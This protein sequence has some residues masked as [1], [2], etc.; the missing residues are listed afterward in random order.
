MLNPANSP[1]VMPLLENVY[2]FSCM[3]QGIL[4]L[5]MNSIVAAGYVPNRACDSI[6][7]RALRMI[8]ENKPGATLISEGHDYAKDD[9][10][11]MWK[12]AWNR[13]VSCLYKFIPKRAGDKSVEHILNVCAGNTKTIVQNSFSHVFQR[14]LEDCEPTEEETRV[15][16]DEAKSCGF[17]VYASKEERSLA[18]KQKAAKEWIRSMNANEGAAAAEKSPS[19]KKLNEAWKLMLRWTNKIR[20]EMKDAAEKKKQC[21]KILPGTLWKLTGASPLLLDTDM[22]CALADG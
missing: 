11:N 6:Q 7:W 15:A 21:A 2:Q 10:I 1:V 14:W 16:I 9:S 3:V 5:C 8:L 4:M 20:S 19:K 12:D 13:H 18:V 17:I 22:L